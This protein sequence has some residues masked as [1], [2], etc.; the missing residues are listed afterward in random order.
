MSNTPPELFIAAELILY[1]DCAQITMPRTKGM[2]IPFEIVDGSMT[3]F[4]DEISLGVW[5][6]QPPNSVEVVMQSATN[7]NASVSFLTRQLKWAPY[8]AAS[9]KSSAD[10]DVFIS[11]VME[12]ISRFTITTP[13]IVSISTK[14]LLPRE[15]CG[16]AH[17]DTSRAAM[18]QSGSRGSADQVDPIDY[19][20]ISMKNI[21]SV[22]PGKHTIHRP[23]TWVSPQLSLELRVTEYMKKQVPVYNQLTVTQK[24][25]SGGGPIMVYAPN[26]TTIGRAIVGSAHLPNAPVGTVAHLNLDIASSAMAKI[27]HISVSKL[28]E[29]GDKNTERFKYHTRLT[30]M[31]FSEWEAPFT[32][33]TPSY[34]EKLTITLDGRQLILP[35]ILPSKATVRIELF[36]EIVR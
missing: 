26:N 16:V 17:Q 15:Y 3:S 8:F 10:G 36:Y 9:M 20:L 35:N 27:K 28:P 5:T 21:S 30:V 2:I 25:Y 29:P 33:E 18:L 12:N 31:N 19:G 1:R 4:M 13:G 34:F 32:I 23:S 6:Y 24:I 22:A 7:P 11:V 14:F